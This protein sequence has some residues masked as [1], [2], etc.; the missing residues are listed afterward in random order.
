MNKILVNEKEFNFTEE[1]LPILIHG[2]DKSGA[3]LYTI[4]IAANLFSQKEKLV[5]LCG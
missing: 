1:N 4:A 3:S 2:E 5:I